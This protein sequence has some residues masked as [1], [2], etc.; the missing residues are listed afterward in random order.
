MK[1]RDFIKKSSYTALGLGLTSM[2]LSSCSDLMSEAAALQLKGE[3]PAGGVPFKIS[4]AQW[5][6]HKSFWSG[7][8]DN[9]DFAKYTKETFGIDAI[10]YVNQFFSDKANDTAYLSQMNQ[11]A[12]DNGVKNQLIMIDGE[13]NLGNLDESKRLQAVENHY[14]WIDA[15]KFLNCH[16]IRV[17]AAG[18]GEREAVASAAVDSL[19]RL[20]EYGAK[21]EI[22]VVVENH[23][24]YSGD[25][26]WLAGVMKQ[27]NHPRCG[28]LPDFG[29][30]YVNLFP[31][32]FYDPI[33]G[34]RELMPF[35]KGVSAKTHDFNSDGLDKSVDFLAMMDIVQEFD[36]QGYVGIEYEGYKLSEEAGIKATKEL[37]IRSVV[38]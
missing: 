29:N 23:G 30:F 28:T 26:S 15:A 33:K 4:L 25:A 21:E 20:C 6:L 11:R 10:E 31:P 16:T 36:Y 8:L 32:K 3:I 24:G 37:M 5:S 38:G 1:R 27:V 14:K 7:K 35:A 19:G 2:A 34:L 17:N 22:N 12:D 13:G 9:L 18:K